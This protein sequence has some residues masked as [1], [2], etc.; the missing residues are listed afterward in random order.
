MPPTRARWA[1][2]SEAPPSRETPEPAQASGLTK[3]THGERP[4][5]F[6]VGVG[7]S[8]GGLDALQAFLGAVP[9]APGIAIVIVTHQAPDQ[10]SLLPELLARKTA[11]R[12]LIADHGLEIEPD[13]VYVSP[14][15]KRL[16]LRA[17][18]LHLSDP[19][20]DGAVQ[21]PIDFFFRELA[22]D[23]EDRAICIVLSGTGTDGTLGLRAIKAHGGLAIA[24]DEKSAQYAGMPLSA[25]ATLLVDHV[26]PPR[27]MPAIISSYARAFRN[28]SGGLADGDIAPSEAV[29]AVLAL[30]HRRS[31]HDFKGYKIPAM[32]RRI[33]RRMRVHQI[34]AVADYVALLATHPHELNLL[35][36]EVLI[37][38]T[39][40]FRDREV[41]RAL[42][43][44]LRR[45]AAEQA[46]GQVLRI[47]V[48]A[49][50]TGEEAYSLA[51][52]LH[53]LRES[54]GRPGHIQVFATD[55]DPNVIDHARQG[56]YPEGVA[57]DIGAERLKRFFVREREGYRIKKEI[58]ELCVFA[59]QSLIK[60]PPFTK[61]DLLSC[62]NLLI[63]LNQDTQQR[64]VPL[65]HYALEPGG[66]LLLGTSETISGFEQLFKPVDRRHKIYERLP[67]AVDAS[68]LLEWHPPW[69]LPERAPLPS[70]PLSLPTGVA[71]QSGKLLLDRFAPPTLIVNAGGDIVYVHGRTGMYLELGSGEP[72]SNLFAMAREGLHGALAAAL[73]RAAKEDREIVHTGA[74]VRCNGEYTRVDVIVR[75]LTEPEALRGLF[76]LSLDAPLIESPRRAPPARA[77]GRARRDAELERELEHARGALQGSIEELQSSNEELKSMNEE[78]QSTNEELQS[79]NEELQTSKEELK[80]MNEELHT[81]NLELQTKMEELS[82]AKDDMAN[83]LESTDIATLFLDRHLRIKRFTELAREV[84]NLIPGDVGRPLHDLVSNLRYDRLTEEARRV[85]ETLRPHEVEVQTNQGLWRLVRIIPY[86]TSLD[87]IDGV[88]ISFL[89]IDRVKRAEMMETSRALTDSIVHTVREPLAVLDETLNIVTANP[90]FFALF[91]LA[92]VQADPRSL[93]DVGGGVFAKSEMRALLRRLL[94]EGAPFDDVGLDHHSRD[95]AVRRLRVNARRLL[96][97]AAA[98]GH[99]LLALDERNA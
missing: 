24:Q 44:L 97:P 9:R 73:R 74:Q 79:S 33:Q 89:D 87:V 14:P 62:R 16:G 26:S 90:A 35:F 91:D 38:V 61:V 71:L 72:H 85:L 37:S 93:F 5:F 80:S 41:F 4:G 82:R 88:A 2:A 78:L 58:R 11:L 27:E 68:A 36:S 46:E 20:H 8:A 70:Q 69:P 18:V 86:R 98:P 13:C 19:I 49:C 52:L 40:F 54:T 7:A 67:R 10:K 17:G 77:R 21:L 83:L 63:Y 25:A 47:W 99:L 29:H 12:V 56:L 15:G 32:V 75:R 48:A 60:D 57:A 22:V 50:S 43:A 53:E 23:Q 45:R 94:A 6:T 34:E 76:R 39:G 96:G 84:I 59:V 28:G 66:L 3:T 31:G 30:L 95:G 42:E 92:P 1:P 55:I 65:F 81:V 51:M 64:L